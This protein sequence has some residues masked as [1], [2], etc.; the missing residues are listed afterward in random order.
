MESEQE[1]SEGKSKNA[2]IEPDCQ[3][4]IKRQKKAEDEL[5]HLKEKLR[6]VR[7][8]PEGRETRAA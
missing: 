6:K 8:T 1:L 4:L 2:S 7:E 3:K 5:M